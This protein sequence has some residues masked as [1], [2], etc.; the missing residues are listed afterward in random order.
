LP[1]T[2]STIRIGVAPAGASC[3][4]KARSVLA[5]TTRTIRPGAMR[6][7]SSRS[8]NSQ[9]RRSALKPRRSITTASARAISSTTVACQVSSRQ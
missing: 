3:S 8:S 7:P 1:R 9:P 2:I 5:S 4:S 6:A